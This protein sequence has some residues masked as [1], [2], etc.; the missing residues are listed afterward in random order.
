NFL[1]EVERYVVLNELKTEQGK[2]MV[3]STLLSAGSIADTWWNK[4]DSTHKN[5][6]VDVKA[7]FTSRWP[8]ITVAEKTGLDY[9]R[10]ILAL[11][12]AEDEVGKQI[13]VAG[14]PT[15]A[16]L[17]FHMQLQQ[18]VNEAGANT[19]AGLVYQV[20]ENL[21]TVVKELTT[22]GIADWVQFLNEIK[23]LDT[24]KLREKAET[25]RKKKEEEKARNARLARLETLQTDAVEVMRLQLQRASI[26]STPT[27][28]TTTPSNATSRIRY[29]AKDQTSSTYQPART[30][31][32]L[33][34]EERELIRSRINNTTHHQDTAT[35]RTAYDNQL[36]QWFAKYGQNGRVTEATQ[37][38]LR[39]G[40]ATICSGECF[41]CGAH[42]HRS[43]ECPVPETSQLPIQERIWRSLAARAL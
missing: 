13:T 17:Q 16:H 38:P 7:A 1:R 36:K 37:F 35:G 32:P 15:W 34:Q 4:L 25:A 11:C 6:W 22:P 8:A 20:Q 40:S 42:G 41:K 27:E 23:A 21:P 3:F 5:T 9:Q 33:T 39:P 31:Q 10:E 43:A 26:G 18:L 29:I 2:I 28:R 14:V 30:R 12:L 24:N 19:T